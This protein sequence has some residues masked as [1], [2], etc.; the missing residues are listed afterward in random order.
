MQRTLLE[1]FYKECGVDPSVVS[2]LEGHGPGLWVHQRVNIK[3]VISIDVQEPELGIRKSYGLQMSFFVKSARCFPYS[4][5]QLNRIWAI[6]NRQ[7][8]CAPW[9]RY[10]TQYSLLNPL[11]PSLIID[12]NINGSWLYNAKFK[13]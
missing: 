8:G 13:F 1:E 6:P 2:Y 10:L 12:F 4:S 3:S 11:A 9:S 5:A 7:Q